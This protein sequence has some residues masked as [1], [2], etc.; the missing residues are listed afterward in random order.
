MASKAATTAKATFTTV[1]RSV[2]Q[3]A[4]VKTTTLVTSSNIANRSQYGRALLLNRPHHRDHALVDR[5]E[6]RVPFHFGVRQHFHE[7]VGDSQK[8]LVRVVQQIRQTRMVCALAW[9]VAGGDLSRLQV[10]KIAQNDIQQKMAEVARM[11]IKRGNIEGK[12]G[13]G[14]Q[15]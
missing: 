1:P 8:L 7:S 10:L 4:T 11:L 14:G 15:I 2:N 5:Q 12:F 6:W 3:W 13:G 9:A